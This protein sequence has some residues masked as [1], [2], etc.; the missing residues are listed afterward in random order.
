MPKSRPTVLNGFDFG[1]CST[2]IAPNHPTEVE[3][4]RAQIERGLGSGPSV[5]GGL[6]RKLYESQLA[7]PDKISF[8]VCAR[9]T[10]ERSNGMSVVTAADIFA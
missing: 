3:P 7:D 8:T 10:V 6:R 4:H 5:L 9:G 1:S 2:G